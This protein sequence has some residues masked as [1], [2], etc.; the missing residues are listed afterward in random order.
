MVVVVVEVVVVVV[1][2]VLVV[3]VGFWQLVSAVSQSAYPKYA[4]VMQGQLVAH[5][6]R[7]WP[8]DE[9]VAFQSHLQPPEQVPGAAVED[10]VVDGQAVVVEPG[11]G[12]VCQQ[13]VSAHSQSPPGIDGG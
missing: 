1:V 12:V 6:L 5:E 13:G 4:G 11:G 3:V 7:I 8:Q 10:V 9:V 2:E